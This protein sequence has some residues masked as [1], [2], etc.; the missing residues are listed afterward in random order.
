MVSVLDVLKW[1]LNH[2]H[3]RA[4]PTFGKFLEACNLPSNCVCLRDRRRVNNT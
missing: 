1:E 2:G 4:C 3:V